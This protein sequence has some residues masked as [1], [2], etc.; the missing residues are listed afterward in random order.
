MGGQFTEEEPKK[1]IQGKQ[2]VSVTETETVGYVPGGFDMFHI[3]HL[4]ILRA[5]REQCSRL[6]VGVASDTSLTAMKGRPP[7]VPHSERMQLVA[8]INFVDDVVADFSQDK[9]LAWHAHPFDLL[10]KGDDW[11]G[12]AKGQRLED[13]MAEVGVTVVYLPYTPST[14]STMLRQF[15]IGSGVVENRSVSGSPALLRS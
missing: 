5:A 11:A 13:E 1:T 3:G 12:T 2:G 4:N 15:L 10:F 14:S 7:V 8:H 6:V 9:R